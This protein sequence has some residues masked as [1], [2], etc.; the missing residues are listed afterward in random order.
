MAQIGGAVVTNQGKTIPGALVTL[1]DPNGKEVVHDTTDEAGEWFIDN[2]GTEAS[3]YYVDI[4]A[5]GYGQVIYP[6]VAA[7]AIIS[8]DQ[9]SV[10]PMPK[11]VWLVVAGI[12]IVGI[13]FLVKS[14]KKK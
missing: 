3:G 7:P 8:M 4:T 2:A 11:W 1:R 13:I 5:P 10:S 12:A 9:T 6:A 14:L